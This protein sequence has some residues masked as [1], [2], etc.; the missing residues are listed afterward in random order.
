LSNSQSGSSNIASFGYNDSDIS[1][2]AQFGDTPS[3]RMYGAT[4]GKN[5]ADSNLNLFGNYTPKTHNFT[6]G[7]EYSKRFAS[8]GMVDHALR[9]AYLFGGSPQDVDP[10]DPSQWLN[11]AGQSDDVPT[12]VPLI[13]SVGTDAA[14]NTAKGVSDAVSL[15]HEVMTG[16]VDPMS[17]E[18]IQRAT[19]LALTTMGGG[20]GGAEAGEGET[21]LGSGP[22]RK[23][24]NLE[25]DPNYISYGNTE[26]TNNLNKFL[27][28]NHPDVPDVVYH[29]TNA[30]FSQ[31]SNELAGSSTGSESAK[32]GHWFVD[33]PTVANSYANF[34]ATYTPVQN[35]LNLADQ[36]AKNQNWDKYD[37]YINEAE[38][39][40][41][42]F[43]DIENRK[44]GQNII[45]AHL[46]LKNPYVL[47]ANGE[48]YTSIEGGL[49]KN[50]INAKKYGHDGVII[51]NLDDAAG[52]SN[53]PANH[54]LVFEPNQIKSATGN[55]GTFDPT[56]PD[57]TKHKGGTVVN[58]ALSVSSENGSTLPD[59]DVTLRQLKRG[60]P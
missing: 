40:E 17:D 46:A 35:L 29:G 54:Y 27:Q 14:V 22:V 50:I 34:S 51:K 19:D 32:L 12:G 21:I 28:D 39:L 55:M 1:S 25:K 10:N 33:N 43:N 24:L 38:K 4:F 58:R 36:N 11:F 59:A 5:D 60:R 42:S 48:T 2:N 16:E 41:N 3:G 20:A 26:R 8:G 15:P 47:D 57:I 49:T 23:T 56:N 7:I 52:L 6:G 9:Q 44:R 45:P 18:G 30:N 37:Y 53:I 13:Q 31:F